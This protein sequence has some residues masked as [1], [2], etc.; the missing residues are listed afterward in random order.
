MKKGFAL[1]F[2]AIEFLDLS[3][4]GKHILVFVYS[5]AVKHVSDLSRLFFGCFGFLCF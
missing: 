4:S 3:F 1:T 2:I 5:I